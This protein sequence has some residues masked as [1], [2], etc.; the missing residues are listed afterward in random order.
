MDAS[1]E[2]VDGYINDLFIGPDGALDKAQ[3]R[4]DEASLPQIQVSPSQ[5]KLLSL[6]VRALRAERVLEIGTLGG[7]STIWLA[8]GLAKS[9]A[10]VTL[11]A[12]PLHAEVARRNVDAAGVGGQVEIVVGPALETLPRLRQDG[13]QPFDLV[14]IDADKGNYPAY[15]DWSVRLARPGA[16]I[17]ADNVI[18]GGAV[19]DPDP[20]DESAVGAAAFNQA[21]AADPRLDAVVIQLAGVKGHDGLA[22]AVVK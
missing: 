10:V 16:V 8:R 1:F 3:R 7:Y 19:L 6:L 21:L 14:F 18:R 15:L 12:E 11:E 22:V 4:A 17:L 2:R 13:R 20:D 5:G 9:G